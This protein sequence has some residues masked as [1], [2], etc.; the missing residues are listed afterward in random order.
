ML[1]MVT[2]SIDALEEGAALDRI[3]VAEVAGDFC[4]DAVEIDNTGEA[5]VADGLLLDTDPSAT[6]AA[7]SLVV[8]STSYAVL[9]D[10]VVK[11]TWTFGEIWLL[12]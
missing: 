4:P 8:G 3:G 1:L 2:Q 5:D 9:I 7:G 6:L 12:G 11:I 10:S